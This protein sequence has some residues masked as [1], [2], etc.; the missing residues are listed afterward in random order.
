MFRKVIT[1]LRAT[2]PQSITHFDGNA[3]G[4]GVDGSAGCGDAVAVVGGLTHLCATKK[5]K[6]P[7]CNST[8]ARLIVHVHGTLQCN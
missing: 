7:A 2:L 5:V 6:T 4:H 1:S 3:G 8:T